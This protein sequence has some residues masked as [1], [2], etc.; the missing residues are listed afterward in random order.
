V[1]NFDILVDDDSQRHVMPVREL[2]GASEQNGAH[3]AIHARPGPVLRQRRRHERLEF[4]TLARRTLDHIL[5]QRLVG[6]ATHAALPG[7]TG[8]D[9]EELLDDL[10]RGVLPLL[11]LVKGLNRCQPCGLAAAGD[12]RLGVTHVFFQRRP[13][14]TMA[15]Q[16]WAASPPLSPRSV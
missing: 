16:A 15:R 4:V 6:V 7:F 8:A 3:E 5:E 11:P 10:G 13:R 9:L 12:G 1:G 2:V 14:A